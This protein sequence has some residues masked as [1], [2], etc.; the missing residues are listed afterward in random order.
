MGQ[1]S[2]AEVQHRLNAA[3]DVG[4]GVKAT[5]MELVNEVIVKAQGPILQKFG[6]DPTLRGARRSYAYF[7]DLAQVSEGIAARGKL[8]EHLCKP[9]K[10]RAPHVQMQSDQEYVWTQEGLRAIS[11]KE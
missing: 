6:F 5:Q 1:M 11:G 9:S 3:F 2:T 7:A 10:Q 8:I 4:G